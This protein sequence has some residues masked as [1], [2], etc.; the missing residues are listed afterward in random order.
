MI[1]PEVKE[2]LRAGSRHDSEN[3]VPINWMSAFKL[4][5]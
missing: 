3:N 5:P 4:K 2:G 1:K